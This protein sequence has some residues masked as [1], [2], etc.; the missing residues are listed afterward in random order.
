MPYYILYFN[1]LHYIY[2]I[3][4][5]IRYDTKYDIELYYIIII[6]IIYYI[7]YYAT[8]FI[9]IFGAGGKP[10][11][12]IEPRFLIGVV[13]LKRNHWELVCT[14]ACIFIESKR[15]FDAPPYVFSDNPLGIRVYPLM[16]FQS[17]PSESPC[18][19]LCIFKES[20]RTQY[21]HPYVFSENP[22]GIPM[23]HPSCIFRESSRN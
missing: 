10:L 13:V 22:L 19:P 11:G 16:C 21:V 14:P 8:Y 9:I 23:H 17:I 20:S 1:K 12:I 18:T 15:N 4:S 3:I 5:C 6:Y 7:L 2:Y